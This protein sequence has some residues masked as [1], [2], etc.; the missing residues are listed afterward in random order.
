MKAVRTDL[1]PAVR[2]ADRAVEAA[3]AQ[4]A[5][6]LASLLVRDLEIEVFERRGDLTQVLLYPAGLSGSYIEPQLAVDSAVELPEE[7]E[8]VAAAFGDGVAGRRRLAEFYRLFRT[9]E[10]MGGLRFLPMVGT[11][12][13]IRALEAPNC[14]VAA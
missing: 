6:A 8:A 11:G 4:I 1:L 3:G 2:A 12:W 7:A 13:L 14:A 5:A 10:G 9:L